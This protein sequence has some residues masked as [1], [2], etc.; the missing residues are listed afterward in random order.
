MIKNAQGWLVL[1]V[2]FWVRSWKKIEK[3]TSIRLDAGWFSLIEK[4]LT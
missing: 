1:G 3:T 2:F 4:I